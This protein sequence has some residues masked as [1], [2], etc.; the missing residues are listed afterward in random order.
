MISDTIQKQIKDNTFLVTGGA[1]FIGSNLVQF[2]L[3]YD[4]K[5]VR[6]LDNLSNGYYENIKDF[7][8]YP[9]FEF[10]EGDI[11]DFNTCLNVIQD[12]DF[13]SHQAAL[14]SVPRSIK[15]PIDT[16]QVNLMGF[17][18]MIE[19]CR[20]SKRIKKFVYAASSS[21]YGDS[22]SL[23][24]I[25][26]NEGKVLSPYALT[27]KV[28]EDY[29][30]IYSKV[31]NFN[32]VGLRYFNVFGPKQNPKNPY[33][34]VIPIFI[35][36]FL[37]GIKPTI[38]GDGK[39][40]RDFTYVDNAILAN[41]LSFY[42]ENFKGHQVFNIACGQK[43]SLI[44]VIE[45]LNDIFNKDFEPNFAN[46]RP[47]DVKHSHASIEKAQEFLNYKPC[48]YFDEGLKKTTQ[49]LSKNENK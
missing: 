33:A 18:N 12:I 26:G 42:S 24:K 11:R 1:G 47:G 9:N 17:I 14:G 40:S 7:I 28:N 10:I 34:A 21:S 15:N 2:L 8:S 43:N 31:Y 37:N 29:A 48:V 5:H 4:A 20:L 25:E 38:N 19:A 46:E 6:V 32:T 39:T 30:E 44:D 27:K 49:F 16:S 23:P 35:D 13:V 45:K 41:I 22:K 3:D 36:C